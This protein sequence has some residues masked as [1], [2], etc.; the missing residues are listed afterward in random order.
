MDNN[1]QV[2]EPIEK[3][4]DAALEQEALSD[5]KEDAIRAKLLE[6]IGIADVDENAEYIDKLVAR[7]KAQ[8]QKFSTV[9][10][11]KINWR[12]KAKQPAPPAKEDP[13]VITKP[14]TEVEDV[15]KLVQ[16]GIDAALDAEK[17][18]EIE[19]TDEA[20]SELKA[21]AQSKGI[22]VRQALK[23]DYFTFLKKGEDDKKREEEA[24]I[25]GTSPKPAAKVSYSKD[26]PPEVD[27]ST[28]EG[29]AAYEKWFDWAS[30]QK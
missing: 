29:Q 17:L 15:S 24:S 16:S 27:M 23:S 4:E 22:T 26:K 30:K 21:Y 2:P 11:Q 3:P 8:R 7:E 20:K 12:E 13:A 10:R 18:N 19:L 1:N 28:P 25:S 6:E 5:V 9:V 14:K